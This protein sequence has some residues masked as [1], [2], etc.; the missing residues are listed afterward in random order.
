MLSSRQVSLVVRAEQ[1][2]LR[3]FETEIWTDTENARPGRYPVD[4]E[5]QSKGTKENSLRFVNDNLAGS[6]NTFMV[7]KKHVNCNLNCFGPFF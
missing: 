6:S 1:M 7:H 3:Y 4:M 5:Y 2:I